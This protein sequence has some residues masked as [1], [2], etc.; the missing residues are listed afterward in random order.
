[1]NVKIFFTVFFAFKI[2][3]FK[4]EFSIKMK[5]CEPKY[6]VSLMKSCTQILASIETTKEGRVE[7]YKTVLEKTG[8]AG[9]CLVYQ[10]PVK[11]YLVFLIVISSYYETT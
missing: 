1:M 11:R 7:N 6:S 10:K 2:V 9:C 3:L 8:N 5:E 4:S